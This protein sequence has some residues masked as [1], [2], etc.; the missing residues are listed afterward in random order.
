MGKRPKPHSREPA[1]ESP[2]ESL[3]LDVDQAIVDARVAI[4]DGLLEYL[5]SRLWVFREAGVRAADFSDGLLISVLKLIAPSGKYPMERGRFWQVLDRHD[6]FS[7]LGPEETDRARL[8]VD[9]ES[10]FAAAM[11]ETFEDGFESAL[12]LELQHLVLKHGEV[13]LEIVSDL[14]LRERVPR[15]V[16]A[17]ALRCLGGMRNEATHEAR[18]QLL[19]RSLASPSHVVRDG[20]LI[21]LSS[22]RDVHAIPALETAAQTAR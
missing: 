14:I 13:T 2:T 22:L 8:A 11:N 4:D 21:G 20:A 5:K 18:R 19:E 16:A 15:E 10:L 17:E 9:V 6:P 7:P 1:Q 12:S 3:P